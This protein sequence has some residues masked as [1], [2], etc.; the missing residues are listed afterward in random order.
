MLKNIPGNKAILNSGFL[1]I[2]YSVYAFLPIMKKHMLHPK[3]FP[4]QSWNF[5]LRVPMQ[6]YV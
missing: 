3:A 2:I 1:F 4:C 5:F 6:K